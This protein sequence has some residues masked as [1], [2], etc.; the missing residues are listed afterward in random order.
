MLGQ[1][2]P[3]PFIEL[4]TIQ[5][6]MT[7]M[8]GQSSEQKEIQFSVIDLLGRLI[9]QRELKEA[10]VLQDGSYFI[11]LHASQFPGAGLY[12][13]RITIGGKSMMKKMVV[14]R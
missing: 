8:N 14:A 7:D 6:R 5:L 9:L 11:T 1:N 12:Y 10:V 13:Y 4:T 2:Y 3:N